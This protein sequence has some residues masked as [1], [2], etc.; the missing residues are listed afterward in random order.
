MLSAHTYKPGT[1]LRVSSFYSLF[2]SI[3]E[4]VEE[5]TAL[6]KAGLLLAM[7]LLTVI[8]G[9]APIWVRFENQIKRSSLAY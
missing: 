5:M 2:G 7:I 4:L 3:S 8:S 9:L 1:F 6:L